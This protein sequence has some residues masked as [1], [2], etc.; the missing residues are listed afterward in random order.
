MFIGFGVI[1]NQHDFN[2]LAH[3]IKGW[4]GLSAKRAESRKHKLISQHRLM[5][6]LETRGDVNHH[7]YKVAPST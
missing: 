7:T 6:S 5:H 1:L 3:R 4:F 2:W